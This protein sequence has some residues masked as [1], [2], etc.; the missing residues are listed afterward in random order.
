M[1]LKDIENVG[2]SVEAVNSLAVTSFII[3][4]NYGTELNSVLS[5]CYVSLDNPLADYLPL[6]KDVESIEDIIS[7]F[8]QS[9][10]AGEVVTNGAIYTPEFIRESIIDTVFYETASKSTRNLSQWTCIDIS[11]G[12]GAFLYSYAKRVK[13]H[14]G[15][16]FETILRNLYGIDI[17]RNSI[18]RTRIL[19]SLMALTE[20]E[21]LQCDNLNLFVANSLSF[22]FN[23]LVPVHE[24]GGFDLV[25]GNPP[26][27]RAKH[28]DEASKILL[29][30]WQV[31]RIGNADLYLPFFEIGLSILNS[32]G[33]LG[34]ITVNS[35][36]KSVNARGLRK[37]IQS[38]KF[39]IKI[40]NFGQELIFKNKLAYT[41][42]V[43]LSKRNS[44]GIKYAKIAAKDIV[45]GTVIPMEE[46]PFTELDYHK[47]WNLGKKD[48]LRNIK[49]LE[50]F[51]KPLSEH[52]IR[53]GIATLANAIFIFAPVEEDEKYYY[54]LVSNTK[55]PI[56]RAICK[57]IIKPN[58]LRTECEIPSKLEKLIFPYDKQYR[59]FAEDYFKM[60]YPKAYAYLLAN[61]RVLLNRDK[62]EFSY[63]WYEFGRTQ[64]INNR[65]KKLMF[66]YMTDTPKFIFSDDDDMLIYCGY[67]FY[68]DSK[69]NL[70]VLKRI[71]ESNVFFYYIKHTSKPYSTGYYSYAKNYLK[72]F[73]IC[74]L[75]PESRKELLNMQSKH[76]IDLFLCKQYGLDSQ[77]ILSNNL[78]G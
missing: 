30:R 28:I 22:D 11:C 69:E 7:V 54:V 6:F 15:E 50:S 4:G 27:V 44:E 36:F 64:A 3:N 10:P 56:E 23:A 51:G 66:P 24:N 12:C 58:I 74:P 35:F 71:L 61:K 20:G 33:S 57:N 67:A 77:E 65:G 14:T 59:V 2:L 45:A 21:I 26:Y 42:L 39:S 8:E 16:R 47:G 75:S 53:N 29:H 49:K 52:C 9:I 60:N 32:N 5:A 55:W 34:Y 31:A 40:L 72:S 1:K 18:E 37:Y 63:K 25:I 78:R 76:E 73:T 68:D 17:S 43:Y 19:L 46:I 13:M 48:L 41:C 70:L 62:G 38:N